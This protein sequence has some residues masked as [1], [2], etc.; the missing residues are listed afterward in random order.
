[1]TA[2][3]SP[4]Q[5][6]TGSGVIGADARDVA[7][8]GW[9]GAVAAL[10]EGGATWFGW[11]S[12]VDDPADGVIAVLLQAG[13]PGAPRPSLLR[14]RVPRDGGRLPSV[15]SVFPGAAWHERETAEMFGIAFDGGDARRLLLP[16]GEPTHPLRKDVVLVARQVVPWPGAADPGGRPRRRALPAGVVPDWERSP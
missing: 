5:G 1:M 10:R 7:P 3:G 14:T 15:A 4:G 12:A 8:A 13:R 11:L 2:A 6:V 9:A 16:A